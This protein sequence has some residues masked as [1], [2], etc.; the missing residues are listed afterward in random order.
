[1]STTVTRMPWPDRIGAACGAAYVLLTVVG[2][3]LAFGNSQDPHP[4][5][6][7]D[8]AMFAAPPTA[9]LVAGEIMELTGY[10][11]FLFFLGWFGQQL[12]ARAGAAGWLGGTASL[13]G[14]VALAVKIVSVVPFG[15]AVLDH[16]DLT[17]SQAR[18]L[19]D[20]GGVAFVMMFLPFGAFL[21]AAGA[22]LLASRV[23]GKVAGYAG[24]VIGV[25][26]VA[27]AVLGRTSPVDTNPMPFLLGLVWLLV[28]SV[29]LAWK[30]PR[31]AVTDP[32]GVPAL[33]AA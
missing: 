30:G 12:R 25:L 22:G 6:A 32:A 19:A 2:N 3:Q 20:M 26:T 1:M 23:L 28:I 24:I 7:Q 31:P 16:A 33:A 15:A 29:R 27:V 17:E 8:L 21:V 14:G 9:G 11:A 4:S 10:V 5:G 13:A 18:V